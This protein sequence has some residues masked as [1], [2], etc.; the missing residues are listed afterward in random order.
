V[1]AS[2]RHSIEAGQKRSR[3]VRCHTLGGLFGFQPAAELQER[4]IA[5]RKALTR[6]R[7][8]PRCISGNGD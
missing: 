7:A 2:I 5:I 1:A 4:V 3:K 8:R 6:H